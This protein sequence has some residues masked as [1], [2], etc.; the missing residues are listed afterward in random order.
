[1]L[2]SVLTGSRIRRNII[3]RISLG[4]RTDST[5]DSKKFESFYWTHRKE[6][7]NGAAI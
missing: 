2:R 3:G 7:L 4:R 6:A 1:V 5:R